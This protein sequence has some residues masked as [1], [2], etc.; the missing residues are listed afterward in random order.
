MSV[1][2]ILLSDPP[3]PKAP[4]WYPPPGVDGEAWLAAMREVDGW[5][6]SLS[7]ALPRTMA[8]AAA[9]VIGAPDGR[10]VFAFSDDIKI[11]AAGPSEPLDSSR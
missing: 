5:C 1:L 10:R 11:S 8:E 9:R 3:W 6:P 4:W 2:G 7:E